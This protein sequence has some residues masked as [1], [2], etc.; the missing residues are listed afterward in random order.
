[1]MVKDTN[2]SHMHF[3]MHFI[4][5][6]HVH[7]HTPNIY[8]SYILMATCNITVQKLIWKKIFKLQ[9]IDYAAELR[10]ISFDSI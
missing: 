5:Q 4:M 3:I 2:I 1:M 10:N 8:K 6:R 9:K 7:A